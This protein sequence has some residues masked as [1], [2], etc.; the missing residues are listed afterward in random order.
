MI[1][2]T[3]LVLLTAF[4]ASCAQPDYMTSEKIY[5]EKTEKPT[6]TCAYV[7]QSSQTCLSVEWKASPSSTEPGEL[8]VTLTPAPSLSLSALLW[9]PSMGH[10]SAP[11]QVTQLDAGIYKITKMYFIMPGDWDVRLFL[12]NEKN[13]VVDQVFIQLVVP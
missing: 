7:F 8:S 9:M 13:E 1:K 10:G 5:P 6:E 2:N 3:Y 11:V 12:K 4:L